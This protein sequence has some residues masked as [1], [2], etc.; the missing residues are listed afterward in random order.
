MVLPAF[1]LNKQTKFTQE[2][3]NKYILDLA[4]FNHIITEAHQK[5]ITKKLG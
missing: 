5:Q 4:K 2:S 3:T 1:Y